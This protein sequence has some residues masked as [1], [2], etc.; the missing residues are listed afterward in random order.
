M[1]PANRN[2]SK[3]FGRRGIAT[4]GTAAGNGPKRRM[5]KAVASHPERAP[6]VVV[7]K[8]SSLG[9]DVVTTVSRGKAYARA[10]LA[11][12]T[13][14]IAALFMLTGVD[15]RFF[16]AGPMLI[17]LA[18]PILPTLAA[19]LYIPTV[20]LSDVARLLAVPRGWAD[21]GIGFLLGLGLGVGMAVTS[22]DSQSLITA[23]AITAGGLVGGF[24]FWR[25]QGYP[26]TSS[27]VA[28]AFDEA[29]DKLT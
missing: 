2:R 19:I 20:V 29:Y 18:I 3:S 12:A 4:Q 1:T 23:V 5:E 26:G 16:Q 6:T 27:G 8:P 7:A 24:A 13:T 17:I 14:F 11:G 28:A 25:A 10:V 21:I 22:A 15:N 9:D